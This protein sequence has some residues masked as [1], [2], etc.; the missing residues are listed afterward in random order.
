MKKKNGKGLIKLLNFEKDS[1][2]KLLPLNSKK[3]ICNFKKYKNLLILKLVITVFERNIRARRSA[4]LDKRKYRK[5][6]FSFTN[7]PGEFIKE[8][9]FFE[10]LASIKFLGLILKDNF[11]KLSLIFENQC[12]LKVIEC[13]NEGLGYINKANIKILKV[14]KNFENK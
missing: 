6:I 7:S 1:L 8:F 9:T 14:F 12:K 5:L 3:N 10:K 13:L 2:I 4:R 11:R